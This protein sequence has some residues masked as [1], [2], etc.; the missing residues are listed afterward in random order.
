[1]SQKIEAIFENGVFRPLQ[2]VDLPEHQHVTVQVPEPQEVA[3]DSQSRTEQLAKSEG[4][5]TKEKGGNGRRHHLRTLA[6]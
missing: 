1:M 4:A 5:E 3:T 2:P 6:S